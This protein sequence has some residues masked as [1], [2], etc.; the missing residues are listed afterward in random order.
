MSEIDNGRELIKEFM[1]KNKVSEPDL[2]AAYGKSRIWIQ[3]ALNGKDK[4]PAVNMF[5][6]TVI[7]DYRLREEKQEV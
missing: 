5:I 2:A 7:R 1:A 4:G 6:L 3:R